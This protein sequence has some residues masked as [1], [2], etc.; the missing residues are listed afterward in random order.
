MKDSIPP[1]H[2]YEFDGMMFFS[3]FERGGVYM[4]AEVHTPTRA[5]TEDTKGH[6]MLSS[7]AFCLFPGCPEPR[8]SDP[9][10]SLSL[11]FPALWSQVYGVMPGLHGFVCLFVRVRDSLYVALAGPELSM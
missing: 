3:S 10:I 7:I 5:C 8:I 2:L 6:G 9:A 1:A 4:C 11:F